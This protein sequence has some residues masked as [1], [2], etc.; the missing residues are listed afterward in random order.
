MHSDGRLIRISSLGYGEEEQWAAFLKSAG[1]ATLFHDLRFLAYHAPGRLHFRHLLARRDAEL[2]AVVPGGL[3]GSMDR[4]MFVSPLGASVGGPAISPYLSTKDILELVAALQDYARDQGWAGIQMVLPPSLYQLVPS[5]TLEFALYFQGFR[6]TNRWLCPVI[7]IAAGADG[8]YLGLFR[9]TH[10]N[11]V[12]AGLRKRLR[13]VEGGLDQLTPFLSVYEDTYQRHGVPPTHSAAEIADLLQRLPDRVRVHLVFLDASPV[14]GMLVFLINP[15]V[16]YTFYICVS[17]AHA[18]EPGS[19]VAFASLI[20]SL[21]AQGYRWLDLG[22][23]ARAGNFNSGVTS[24]KEGLGGKGYCR[25]QWNW[26][27]TEGAQSSDTHAR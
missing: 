14:A 25:D 9:D 2:V 10:S 27:V 20:D 13:V 11:R 26:M 21:G 8:R 7:P 16:A 17:T 1:N 12:R 19:V 3:T 15:R 5:D 18:R 23:T 6:L 4:P 22:P 24:F